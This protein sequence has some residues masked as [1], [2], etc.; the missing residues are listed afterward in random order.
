[1]AKPNAV[2]AAA[3]A[4]TSKANIWPIKSSWKMENMTK[5]TVIESN[6]I[7]K[8]IRIR[9]RC[10]LDRNIP[11]EPLINKATEKKKKLNINSL[12]INNKT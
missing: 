10:C 8:E 3:I 1:M 12:E 11:E 5:L 9:I 6:T 2:S 7:S 4:K